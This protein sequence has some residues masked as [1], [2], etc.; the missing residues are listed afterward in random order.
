MV[1][2]HLP[3]L[4]QNPPFIR[5][6][7][8]L[9]RS[10]SRKKIQRGH[11]HFSQMDPFRDEQKSGNFQKPG[12][13]VFGL[14]FVLQYRQLRPS[15]HEADGFSLQ[16]G[17]LVCLQDLPREICQ[18]KNVLG[19]RSSPGIQD[20]RRTNYNVCQDSHACGSKR[21]VLQGW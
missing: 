12:A 1:Q 21:N 8:H 16:T 9:Q 6:P 5:P 17:E 13:N 20:K 2:V 19:T 14:G 3:I 7:R 4:D 18:E 11:Q 15:F 10:R